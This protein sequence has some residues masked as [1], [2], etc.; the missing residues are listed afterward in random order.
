MPAG[1]HT[2]SASSSLSGR[3]QDR[4]L[5][6]ALAAVPDH[7]ALKQYVRKAISCTRG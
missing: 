3:L 6:Q 7:D 2:H 5:Q 1:N 4:S